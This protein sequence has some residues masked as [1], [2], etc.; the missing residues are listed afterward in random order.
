[1]S[2]SLS[3]GDTASWL[4]YTLPTRGALAN[5]KIMYT[6]ESHTDFAFG[7]KMNK[8]PGSADRA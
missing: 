2:W 4:S 1:M 3:L 8:E 7:A 6:A 5:A